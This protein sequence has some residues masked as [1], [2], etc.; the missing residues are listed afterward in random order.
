MIKLNASYSKKV[1]ADQDYSSKSFLACVEVE[2]PTG[3]S[4]KELQQK[5][6]ETFRLVE[7][8]VE[9]EI[10]GTVNIG[11]AEQHQRHQGKSEP[12][13]PASNKQVKYILDLGKAKDMTL[14]AL[15]AE[16]SRL[17]QVDSIYNL[18][19]ADASRYVDV[20]KQAA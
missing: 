2:L 12:Y 14:A 10:A 15:N 1:P 7:E 4:A 9:A 20:L 11:S 18:A 19:K 16:V 13:I 3:A 17:Y 8:S 6:H 5:I